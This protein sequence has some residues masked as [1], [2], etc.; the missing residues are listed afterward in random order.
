M[1]PY[2]F[3][4]TRIMIDLHGDA[5]HRDAVRLYKNQKTLS[6]LKKRQGLNF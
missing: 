6:P 4:L 2:S 5:F 3:Y 1:K